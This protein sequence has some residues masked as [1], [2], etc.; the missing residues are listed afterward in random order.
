[1]KICT[2]PIVISGIYK[3]LVRNSVVLSTCCRYK[4]YE[5]L[6]AVSIIVLELENRSKLECAYF[7]TVF[8]VKLKE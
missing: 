7:C 5:N 4:S 8:L 2:A 1:M 6:T 3:R